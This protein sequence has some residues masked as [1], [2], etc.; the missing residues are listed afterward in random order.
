MRIKTI[1]LENIRS[2]LNSTVEFNAGFNCLVGGLGRGKSSILLAID[3]ALFGEPLARSYEYLLREDS[4]IGRVSLEFLKNGREYTI[5]RVLK[6]SDDRIGQD[7]EQLK[8][9]EGEKLI[10]E[11]K[12]EAVTEQLR[13]ITGIDRDLFHEVTWMRQE[14]LKDLLDMPPGQRQKRLDQLFGLSDYEEAWS[15]IR[16]ILRW[17]EGES[18]S[19][20]QDPDIGRIKELQGQYNDAATEFSSKEMELQDLS[21][22]LSEAEGR[23]KVAS[24][25]VDD[26]EDLR[27]KNEEL[28][29]E[30]AKLQERVIAVEDASARLMNEVSNRNSTIKSLE[31][32]LRSHKRQEDDYRKMLQEVG[33]PPNQT[34]GQLIEYSEVLISQMSSIQGE[35]EMVDAKIK[36]STLSI[37]SLEAKN[38]CPLCL[39]PISSDYK[40]GLFKRLEGEANELKERID[41]LKSNT[42]E[43]EG[44]RMI[45]SSVTSNIQLTLSRIEETEKQ[46]EGE[47]SLLSTASGEFEEMQREEEKDR[48][49][50]AGLRREIGEF[51]VSQL[52][53]AQKLR[54]VAFDD[55]SKIKYALQT[56]ESQ[57]KEISLRID[58]LRERLESAEKK[59]DRLLKVE[60]ILEL[61][62][63]I[64]VAYRSIQPKLRSEFITYLERMVQQELDE[65]MG[66]EN[67]LLNARIDENYTAFVESPDGHERDVSNISGGERTFLA[68]AYRLGIGQL[69]MQSRLGHGLNMLLLD[70]PTE[71]LGREDGSIE[72]LAEA[73]SRLKTVEQ[74]IAVT[75]SEAFAERAD[76]VI[77]IDKED[78]TSRVSIEEQA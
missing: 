30:E 8:L 42:Q 48:E 21:R 40:Q 57:K 29:R 37:D 16:P 60:K 1:T 65:L 47:R 31:D 34:V 20:R 24:A 46:L 70:E 35:R 19:L 7:M 72:R 52:D 69:I 3:F 41:E 58:A 75:H 53:A 63:E 77:R 26:L 68:F 62:K 50:L 33:L 76:H 67:T 51:D 14:H 45:I 64:R 17:Y 25:N 49:R 18:N 9:F 15:S 13:L 5:H 38:L 39:Q 27:R 22:R 2:H 4:E 23:L 43:L 11:M 54:D 59:V 44:T 12:S 10:A 74:V 55:Y 36:E 56:V 32:R 71:S 73:I 78:N 6:R 28:R 61:V 66:F